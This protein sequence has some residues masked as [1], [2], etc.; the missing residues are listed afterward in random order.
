M[1]VILFFSIQLTIIITIPRVLDDL[2][3]NLSFL[4]LTNIFY[5]PCCF[6]F[7]IYFYG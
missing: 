3:F 6:Y 5:Y 2:K 7:L 4:Y 1:L